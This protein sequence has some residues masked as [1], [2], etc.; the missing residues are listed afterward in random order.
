[1]GQASQRRSK[2]LANNPLCCFCGGVNASATVDHFPPR[3]IFT[4]RVWPEGFE[5]PA[6]SDC[7]SR[8]RQIEQV[9][10]LYAMLGEADSGPE[11]NKEF[12]KR[13]RGVRNN[14]PH[15]VP[16]PRTTANEKKKFIAMSGRILPPGMTTA[17][18]PLARFPKGIL[19][20]LAPFFAK[21]FC[22]LYY[23]ETGV[24]FPATG[25]ISVVFTTPDYVQSDDLEWFGRN[26]SGRRATR[27]GN[28][29]IS[30]QFSYFFELG[31]EGRVFAALMHIRKNLIVFVGGVADRD[32]PET[33][34]ETGWYDIFG[35]KLHSSTKKENE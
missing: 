34:L 8:T 35:R 22:A 27:R 6:C 29:S 7:N 5:F 24:I 26:L 1:M 10:G 28:R 12:A 15:L 25:A 33:E 31:E 9:V 18:L 13:L 19:S 3:V 30:D 20:A 21:L 14:A 16:D 17:G 2:F 23:R 4:N 11:R 32:I